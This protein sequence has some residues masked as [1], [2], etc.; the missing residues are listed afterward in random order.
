MKKRWPGAPLHGSINKY[1]DH[2]RKRVREFEHPE[3]TSTRKLILLRLVD[4]INSEDFTA[5]PAL[6]TLAADLG[7]HRS[8]AIRA[9]DVAR[10]IG[11][12]RRLYKGGKKR[13][14]GTSNRYVFQLDTVAHAPPCQPVAGH[15]TVAGQP[16]TQ[17]QTSARHSG[18]P[19]TLSSK[20]NLKDNLTSAPTSSS[21]E[22]SAVVA[23]E[24]KRVGEKGPSAPKEGVGEERSE[25]LAW[26]TP[27]LTE[28]EFTPAFR[29]LHERA[30]EEVYTPGVV[31]R[32]FYR[33]RKQTDEEFRAEMAARGVDMS[34]SRRRRPVP[35]G[36]L[37][38]SWSALR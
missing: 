26:T 33:A 27:S 7:V 12:L 35:M 29:K 2:C 21:F 30:T 11:L 25:S 9:V 28:I 8:T 37:P 3:L 32:R 38:P 17:W 18:T 5:W 10:K 34:A 1:R 22:N 20:D 16:S 4:Y 6:D 19:A 14:R 13:G 15:D 24:E 31:P 23:N 36:K